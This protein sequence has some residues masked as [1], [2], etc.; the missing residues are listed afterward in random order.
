MDILVDNEAKDYITKKIKNRS[1]SI[2]A[3][4]R[5]GRS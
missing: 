3:M 5:P 4:E 2:Q 1:I